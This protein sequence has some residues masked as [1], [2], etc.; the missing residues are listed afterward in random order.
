M[1]MIDF[2]IERINQF[3]ENHIF[4]VFL[5]PTHDEDFTIPTNVKVKL[6]GVKEYYSIGDKKPHVQYTIYILPTNERADTFSNLYGDIYGRD[7]VINT[8]S[9]EYANVRWVMNDKLSDFLRYFGVDM[10]AICTKVINK[11]DMKKINESL[12]VEGKLDKITRKLVQDII[13]IFKYQRDGEFTLPEDFEGDEMV[14]TYP[15]FD[16]FVIKLELELSDEVDTVE[17]DAELRY[18]DDDMIVTIISNPNARNSILD[19]LTHEL[20]DVVRHELEH[21]KQ[22]DEGY[23]SPDEEETDP[24]KYYTKQEELDAQKAGFKKKSKT[25]KLDFET[26]VRNWFKKYPHKHKLKPDQQEKV[27][28]QI[29]NRDV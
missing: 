13:R 27:I 24:E 9:Q 8:S 16:G 14:Y 22:H 19:E 4:E 11:V 10:P 12:I 15:G 7:T 21:I 25:A 3:F 17:V 29:I 6:T 5:Q 1:N 26:V 2:P 18:D 28:Q 20:N 23:E